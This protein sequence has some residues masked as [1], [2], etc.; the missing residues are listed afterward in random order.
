MQMCAYMTVHVSADTRVEWHEGMNH[1][2]NTTAREKCP[3]QAS[4]TARRPT[5]DGNA[6]AAQSS[7]A[8]RKPWLQLILAGHARLRA[9]RI[10]ARAQP[11]RPFIPPVARQKPCVHAGFRD[12]TPAPRLNVRGRIHKSRQVATGFVCASFTRKGCVELRTCV[13]PLQTRR[14]AEAAL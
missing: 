10:D 13:C 2:C 6:P 14:R 3:S 5:R 9:M 7:Y 8:P 11:A 4:H 1:I 12:E